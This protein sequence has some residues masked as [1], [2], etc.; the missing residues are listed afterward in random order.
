MD[1]DELVLMRDVSVDFHVDGKS[2]VEIAHERNLSRF[3][4]AR[5]L[6][7]AREMGIVRISVALPEESEDLSEPLA[8][9]LGVP[10]IIAPTHSDARQ[11]RDLLA[12]TLARTLRDQVREGMTV[13]LSWSRTLETAAAYIDRLPPCQVVQLVGA[14]PVEGSGDSLGLIQHFKALSGVHTY[15]IWAPLTVGD[16]ATA[17]GLRAQPQIAEA[18]R[19]ADDLDLAVVAIGGWSPHSSTVYPTLSRA[20]LA[21]VEEHQVVGECSGRLFDADG[22]ELHA[23]LEERVVAVT[24]DQLR[25]TPTVI[26]SG[27]GRDTAAAVRAGVRGGFV[28][29]LVL[30]AECASALNQLLE[31]P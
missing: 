21:A 26:A 22:R 16:A 13:G 10:V 11:R 6:T 15:P 12:R 14:Q 31:T 28:D 5:L 24:L 7:T 23:P 20:D 30:D 18:L 27:F 9:T 1:R 2:K 17:A 8:A 19:K 25:R 4:V 29:M 3:R